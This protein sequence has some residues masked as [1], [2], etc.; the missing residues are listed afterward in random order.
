VRARFALALASTLAVTWGVTSPAVALEPGV[1]VD[2]GSPAGKEYSVPL[3]ALRHAGSGKGE[4]GD[5]AQPLFGI[6]VSPPR[7]SPQARTHIEGSR[8]TTYAQPTG[9]SSSAPEA[10]APGAAS[11]A[12]TGAAAGSSVLAELTDHGSAG[13]AVFLI[14]ALVVLGGLTLGTVILTTRRRL[15]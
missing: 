9:G 13:P 4:T 14:A 6:G 12:P 10:R 5:G 11:G 8:H 3:S 1:Y 2:P 7:V 15:S